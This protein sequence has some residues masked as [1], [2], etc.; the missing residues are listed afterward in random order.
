VARQV[1]I[2]FQT[3]GWKPYFTWWNRYSSSGC[4]WIQSGFSCSVRWI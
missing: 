2:Y 1:N 4:L 3:F